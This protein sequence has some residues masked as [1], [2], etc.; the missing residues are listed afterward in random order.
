MSK[1]RAPSR[2]GECGMRDL[3]PP[4][5]ARLARALA[6][7][8]RHRTGVDKALAEIE[9]VVECGVR[10]AE[11]GMGNAECGPRL[12]WKEGMMPDLQE[13]YYHVREIDGKAR[14]IGL[15]R[16]NRTALVTSGDGRNLF[17]QE[18][19]TS[20]RV[21]RT[22]LEALEYAYGEVRRE[23]NAAKIEL[24]FWD[25]RENALWTAIDDEKRKGEGEG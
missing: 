7:L 14:V 6:N 5:G 17:F 4:A 11:C 19:G 22:P 2:K 3:E 18:Y 8:R 9:A 16:S 23:R 15:K 10:S 24:N 12:E 1:T 21:C 13:I 20:W 25:K